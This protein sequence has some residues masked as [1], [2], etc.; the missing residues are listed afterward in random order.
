MKQIRVSALTGML[1]ALATFTFAQE[2]APASPPA[3][4]SGKIGAAQVTV[5]Y[6]SP[7]V[8]GREVWGKLVPYGQ[9]WRTGAN[10]A[11]TITFDKD[12]AIEGQPLKAG[13]YALF[14]IPTENEWTVIFSKK[15]KQSGAFDYKEAEDALRVKVKPVP[16][17]E[18]NERLK[19][20]VMSKGKNAGTI[21]M[22]WEKMEVPVAVKTATSEA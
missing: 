1:L 8:K 5:N 17:Q 21:I 16:A 9:V 7:S 11:T 3:T 22:K 20:D 10:A 4:A 19:F 2:K 18:M 6:S 12:L 13:T 14:T 15:A